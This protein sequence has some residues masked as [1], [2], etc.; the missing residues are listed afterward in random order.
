MRRDTNIGALRGT[1]PP[2]DVFQQRFAILSVVAD[3][4]APG[5]GGRE[6]ELSGAAPEPG[7]SEPQRYVPA[8]IRDPSFPAS[9]RG[10]SRGAVD[11]YVNRVNRL[12]AELEVSASPRAAVRHALEQAGQQVSGLL[13]QARETAERI[14]ASGRQEA[15]ETAA[16]G[17][18]EAAELVRNASTEADR[19]RAG[20]ERLLADARSEAD[21]IRTRAGA[22]AEET[23]ARS[24]EETE[25]R[26]QRLEEELAALRDEAEARLHELGDE[27]AAVSMRGEELVEEIHVLARD[28]MSWQARRLLDSH[29]QSPASLPGTLSPRRKTKPH[30]STSRPARLL[31]R[32][33]RPSPTA[34]RRRRGRR[35][36]TDLSAFGSASL[37]AATIAATWWSWSLSEY[38]KDD[39]D[40]ARHCDQREQAGEQS[41]GRPQTACGHRERESSPDRMSRELLRSRS[42]EAVSK[43]RA[44]RRGRRRP[45]RDRALGTETRPRIESGRLPEDE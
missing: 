27:T 23:L 3:D 6:D 20:T 34:P 39:V 26:R 5:A 13:E 36:G 43:Q 44:D 32:C 2:A 1:S 25:K 45:R 16:R 17:K 9:V 12:T 19:A 4:E 28:S 21:A 31:D 10:Y 30:P 24:R 22:E 38:R 8:E 37:T 11:A 14:I 15:D 33:K 29:T 35:R 18:A 41:G 7:I 40:D 42:G